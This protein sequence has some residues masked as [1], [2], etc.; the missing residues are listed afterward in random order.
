MGA[1]SAMSRPPH[2]TSERFEVIG[3]LARCTMVQH[4]DPASRHTEWFDPCPVRFFPDWQLQRGATHGTDDLLRLAVAV[5]QE[6]ALCIA[7]VEEVVQRL[8]VLFDIIYASD[9]L[10]LHHGCVLVGVPGTCHTRSGDCVVP[11]LGVSRPCLATSP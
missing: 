5:H 9:R 6:N 4:G 1:T 11:A 10:H 3:T 7:S 8:E 2:A